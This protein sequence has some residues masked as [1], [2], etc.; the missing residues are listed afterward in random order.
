MAGKQTLGPRCETICRSGAHGSDR[1]FRPPAASVGEGPSLARN[2]TLKLPAGT[3]ALVTSPPQTGTPRPPSYLGIRMRGRR[4]GRNCR[5]NSRRP[6]QTSGIC[7]R[8]GPAREHAVA[9]P[10][11]GLL[12]EALLTDRARIAAHRDLHA[13]RQTAGERHERGAGGH[14]HVVAARPTTTRCSSTGA[15]IKTSVGRSSSGEMPATTGNDREGM[16]A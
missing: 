13:G 7:R 12:A 1:N 16:T 11:V 9:L 6:K 14:R 4:C 8:P 15:C 2:A 10:T 5:P 3:P